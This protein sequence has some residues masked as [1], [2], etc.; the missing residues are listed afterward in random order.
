MELSSL[1]KIIIFGHIDLFQILS[2]GV[3]IFI[4]CFKYL[5]KPHFAIYYPWP[6]IY[7]THN[8]PKNLSLNKIWISLQDP[9]EVQ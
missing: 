9:V 8:P 6:E 1:E 7:C 5:L 4:F 2:L 3:Y